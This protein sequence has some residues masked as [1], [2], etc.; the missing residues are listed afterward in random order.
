MFNRSCL[1]SLSF[2]LAAVLLLLLWLNPSFSASPS[3][4]NAEE[5]N[6]SLACHLSEQ[7]ESTGPQAEGLAPPD[8][9]LVPDK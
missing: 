7:L 6:A 3:S 4:S 1:T 9:K 8:S 5:E 2:W